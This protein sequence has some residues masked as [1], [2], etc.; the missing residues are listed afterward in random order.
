MMESSEKPGRNCADKFIPLRSKKVIP[1]VSL[2]MPQ[3]F[4]AQFALKAETESSF[5][6]TT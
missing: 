1:S 5:F 6:T 4:S 2:Y 3:I